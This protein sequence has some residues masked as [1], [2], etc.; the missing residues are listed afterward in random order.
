MNGEENHNDARSFQVYRYAGFWMRLWAYLLDLIVIGS[1]NRLLIYPVFRAMGI[2]LDKGIFEPVGITTAIIFY[3]YFVLM[4]K[5]FG[6]TIG[7]MVFGLKV[8]PLKGISLSWGTV[9]FR[10]WVG[11]FI[12]GF[13]M[14]A[15]IVVAFLPKKQGIHD[16]FADTTVIHEH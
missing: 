7:K 14:I 5:Y 9:L 12:S 13:I 3:L 2:P 16:L 8:V 15:Y 6:Q 11:R 1:L 4:T 10:E